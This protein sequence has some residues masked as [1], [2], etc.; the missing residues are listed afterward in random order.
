MGLLRAQADPRLAERPVRF[1][2]GK[3]AIVEG[4]ISVLYDHC[5][6]FEN[7]FTDTLVRFFNVLDISWIMKFVRMKNSIATSVD[8]KS[9]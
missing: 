4:H 7:I 2:G 6:T 8:Q 3:Y 5:R 1:E 9:F